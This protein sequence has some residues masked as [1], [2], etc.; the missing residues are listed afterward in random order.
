MKYILKVIL[1]FNLAALIH[2]FRRRPDKFFQ[3]CICALSAA[4]FPNATTNLPI[5]TIQLHQIIGKNRPKISLTVRPDEEGVLP[6]DQA[7]ALAAIV[8]SEKPG[9]VLEI[10]TFM[11]VTTLLLAENCPEAAIHTVD[12][13]TH[14]TPNQTGPSDLPKDDFHLIAR[15]VVGREFK[16]KAAASRITQ[17]FADTA[18]WDFSN[19]GTPTF[20]F[21]DGSHTYEYCKNDSNKCYEV[22]SGKGVFVW[23]DCDHNHPGVIRFLLEWRSM[24]RDIRRIVGTPLAFWKNL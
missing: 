14:F 22:C 1:G 3:G 20:F 5:P 23:H 8:A 9:A 2:L 7:L 6:Y 19:A 10:G 18:I 12:L 13:P 15:R 17:H 21:I 24:G 4:R 11:G 16:G